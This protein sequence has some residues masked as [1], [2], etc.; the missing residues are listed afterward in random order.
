MSFFR[1]LSAGMQ[2][3]SG[4]YFRT[5]RDSCSSVTCLDGSQD[6]IVFALCDSVVS[7][8]TEGR[9]RPAHLRDTVAEAVKRAQTPRLA[10]LGMRSGLRA[11]DSEGA[12]TPWRELDAARSVRRHRNTANKNNLSIELCNELPSYQCLGQRTARSSGFAVVRWFICGLVAQYEEAPHDL[13][14]RGK[15]FVRG[16]RGYRAEQERGACH[17]VLSANKMTPPTPTRQSCFAIAR[18]EFIEMDLRVQAHLRVGVTETLEG[19]HGHLRRRDPGQMCL[20]C[21]P[22]PC[23]VTSW[24][25]AHGVSGSRRGS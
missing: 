25:R 14:G 4:W 1:R 21:S 16:N 20:K 12:Q 6:E 22:C 18:G 15:T 17:V 24:S 23:S 2:N 8:F 5:Q 7:Q 13:Q 19:G 11:V 9:I 10:L 3:G